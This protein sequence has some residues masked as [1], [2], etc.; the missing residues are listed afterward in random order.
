MDWNDEQLIE[1]WGRYRKKFPDSDW[2]MEGCGITPDEALALMGKS[3]E[4]DRDYL[5][6]SLPDYPEG[7]LY[8]A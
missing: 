2:G 4:T 1:M 8:G 3:I 5:E 6:E 7:T